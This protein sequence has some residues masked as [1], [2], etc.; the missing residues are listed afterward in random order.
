MRL[1]IIFT[2]SP[3]FL[4]SQTQIGNDID[5]LAAGDQS[6][7]VSF[8]SDGT[9]VAIGGPGNDDAGE[10]AGQVRIFENNSGDWV[11]LGQTIHGNAAGDHFGSSVSLSSDG[12]ILAIGSPDAEVAGYVRVFENNSGV[13]TQIGEDINGEPEGFD[14]IG[15]PSNF[16]FGKSVSIS[17]DGSILAIG[18]GRGSNSWE[19]GYGNSSHIHIYE[20]IAGTWQTHIGDYIGTISYIN[21]M[22]MSSDGSTVIVSGNGDWDWWYGQYING[23]IVYNKK[24]NGDWTQEIGFYGANEDFTTYSINSVSL[25]DDGSIIAFGGTSIKVFRKIDENWVQRGE[26]IENQDGSKISLSGDGSV[27]AVGGSAVRLFKYSDGIWTQLGA[28][29]NE[30]ASGDSFGAGLELSNNGTKLVVGAPQNDGNGIDSGRVR[31]Y[32]LSALL[33]SDDFVLSQFS[34]FPNPAKD[35]FTIS[36]NKSLELDHINIYNHLAQL[37]SSTKE[38]TVNT[39][40]LSTGM[41]FVEVITDQGK[42]TKK[43]IVK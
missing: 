24:I 42:A 1:L 2:L 39:S 35:Q 7:Y 6:G 21:D 22:S 8:S 16:S 11:Q 3:F 34:L 32:D 37:M 43:L 20:N 33:S 30:E 12:S 19:S 4:F 26:D 15:S 18:E 23:V 9:V 41:Y 17:D 14:E 31:V 40:H 10:D 29:I 28:D 13:W 5:G 27:L 25:S 36:L 38:T